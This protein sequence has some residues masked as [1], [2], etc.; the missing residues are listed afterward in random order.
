MS[1]KKHIP[2]HGIKAIA[3]A[4][5]GNT[6]GELSLIDRRPR[7]A[8]CCANI[9][10]DFAVLTRDSLNEIFVHHPRPGNKFLLVLLQLMPVRLRETCDRFLPRVYGSPI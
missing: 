1:V 2:G 9:P 6:L 3:E 4:S 10:T 8:R 7:F 5:V